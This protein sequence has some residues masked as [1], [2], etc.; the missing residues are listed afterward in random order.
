MKASKKPVDELDQLLETIEKKRAVADRDPV[1]N[2]A[3]YRVQVGKI[4][5]AKED[6]K[7]LFLDYRR[8]VQDRAAFIVVTGDKSQDFSEISST[9]FGC[10][11]VDADDFY[12]VITN[13]IS[14]RLYEKTAASGNLFDNVSAAFEDVAGDIGIIGFPAFLFDSKYKKM[15]ENK[16]DMVK[17][18][19]RAFNDKIGAE[20]NGLYM[21]NKVSKEAF[22]NRFSSKVIP[23]VIYAKD[24]E[25][26]LELALGLNGLRRIS[27][28]V[29]LITA[30]KTEVDMKNKTLNSLKT[31]NEK[32]VEQTLTKI[33]E[34]LS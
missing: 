24:E 10:F 8:I 4:K 30:G 22:D 20:V 31:I 16:E 6:L 13:K 32:T 19:K 7:D 14:P 15:L 18:I 2:G 28:D 21:V 34:N 9:D 5:K 26:A 17:L 27:Q 11:S 3:T 29:F 1:V 25:L 23:V 12:N 33:K